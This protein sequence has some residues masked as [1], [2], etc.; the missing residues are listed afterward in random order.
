MSGAGRQIFRESALR[1][2]R[3]RTEKDV[4]P[5]LIST[6]IMTAGWLLLAT[7][8][9][10]AVLAWSLRVPTYVSASGV[11]TTGQDAVVFVAPDDAAAVRAGRAVRGRIG[12]SGEPVRGSVVAVATRAIGPDA[13]RRRYR[14]TDVIDEPAVAVAVRL[15]HTLPSRRYAGSRFTAEVETGSERLLEVLP[16]VVMVVG[17]GR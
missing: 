14:L 1:A 3:Q 16:C 5:R 11:L 2:Y 15:D 4:V 8:V 13:A 6:P 17:G 10:V 9:G 12:S 7:L